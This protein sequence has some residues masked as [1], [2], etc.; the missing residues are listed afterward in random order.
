MA[1]FWIKIEK[2]TPDK[3]EIFEIAEILGIDPD[4]VLGKLIRVWAWMDSNSANGHIKSVTNVLV[5][6]VS[7]S[8][9]FADAMKTVGWLGD[10]MIPNFDRHLGESAKKRAKDAERKRLSRDNSD[11]CPQ[12]SVTESGLDKSRED[13]SKESNKT[14][15][16]SPK[17]QKI[18]FNPAAV[19][20]EQ[21]NKNA[22][23]EWI[24]YRKSKG[25]KISE[26]AAKKQ[27]KFLSGYP[28]NVQQQ[29]VDK[30]ITNDYQGLFEPAGVT[31][32]Q[33]PRHQQPKPSLLDRVKQQAE[34]RARDQEASAAGGRE[35]I[36]DAMAQADGDVRIQVCKPIRGDSRRDL[37]NV[38]EGDYRQT[39]GEWPQ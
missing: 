6:R 23:G 27:I 12:K 24:E 36:V 1:D 26:A 7:M 14:K 4:A 10:G 20:T 16:K 15:V 9:G 30:S 5:D 37:D 38:L 22:W 32:A 29:I 25:K 33:P 3:P 21:T 18:K 17:A 31:H 8:Q 39:D 2:S 28:A 11:K 13:K 35:F 34:Q 19:A